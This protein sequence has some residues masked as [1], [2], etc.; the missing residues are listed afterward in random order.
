[1]HNKKERIWEP[2]FLLVSSQTEP[3]YV[4]GLALVILLA[5]TFMGFFLS[6]IFEL[7]IYY[8]YFSISRSYRALSILKLVLK[9]HS[10]ALG[11]L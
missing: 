8:Y 9:W 11:I 5:V 4:F 6:F 10:L 7:I 1:M 2:L 3:Q